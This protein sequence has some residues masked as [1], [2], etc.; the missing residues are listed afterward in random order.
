MASNLNTIVS[1]VSMAGGAFGINL[2]KLTPSPTCAPMLINQR[3]NGMGSGPVVPLDRS[4]LRIVYSILSR[5][6]IP[7][8][9][10][11]ANNDLKALIQPGRVI[12]VCGAPFVGKKTIVKE[13]CMQFIAALVNM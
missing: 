11:K 6:S 7:N 1:T 8:I 4:T 9:Q 3:F 10:M 2:N 13:V 12:Q 5:R